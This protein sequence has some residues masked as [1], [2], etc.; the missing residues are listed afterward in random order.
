MLV[1]EE[2]DRGQWSIQT[3]LS[4][5]RLVI[6]RGKSALPG[7]QMDI[8]LLRPR[9]RGTVRLAS[10]NPTDRPLIDPGYYAHSDDIKQMV[11]G[12]RHVREVMAK[13]AM[14]DFV[15]EEISPGSRVQS[16]QEIE[17]AIRRLGTTGHHP[18]GTC[19]MGPD[20]VRDAVLT[21]ELKV[22]EVEGLR[23]VDASSFPGHISGNPNAAVIMFAE[24]AADMILGKP[25]LPPEDPRGQP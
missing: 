23:V 21:R 8:N 18:V 5:G 13:P 20:H 24:K 16:D 7:M 22:R 25:P 12:L 10:A 17:R 15:G 3:L 1:K 6:A 9:S 14:R 2:A 4:L 11:A 19:A